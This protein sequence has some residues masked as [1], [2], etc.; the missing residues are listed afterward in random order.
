V[1][2]RVEFAADVL[3]PEIRARARYARLYVKLSKSFCRAK[4]GKDSTVGSQLA[5]AAVVISAPVCCT[6][7]PREHR[8]QEWHVVRTWVS[9]HVP[10]NTA[11][12]RA[13]ARDLL[14]GM[15]GG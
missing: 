4:K 11:K 12:E 7:P 14:L 10:E 3:R 1:G 13:R 2:K 5:Y 9:C 6:R 15:R 8:H